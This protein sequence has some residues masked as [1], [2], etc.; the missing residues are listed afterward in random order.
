MSNG[1]GHSLSKI[2]D[3]D[4]CKTGYTYNDLIIMPGIIEFS[5]KDVILDTKISKNFTIK[6]PFVSSPMDTVT[7][8]D[9]AIAMALQGG[10]GFIHC[11]C[12]I[13]KQVEEVKKVKQFTNYSITDPKT[14]KE[15]YTL[16]DFREEYDKYKFSNFPVVDDNNNLVG[17]INIKDTDFIDSPHTK[18]VGDVMTKRD[19][20]I[21]AS[22]ELSLKEAHTILAKTGK[23]FLPII[24][25]I[26]KQESDIVRRKSSDDKVFYDE[27]DESDYLINGKDIPAETPI[28]LQSVICRKDIR[29]MKEYPLCSKDKKGK[30]LVGAAISTHDDYKERATQLIQ[31]G[32]NIILVDSAQ[33]SSSYQTEVI[34]WLKL[35]KLS[36]TKHLTRPYH[37][38]FDII[39]GN[40]VTV[41]QAEYLLEKCQNC[42][43][44]FRVGMGSGSIC[45]TQGVCGVGRAQATAVYHLAKYSNSKGIPII[46]DGGIS[47]SSHII[48]ALLLGASTVMMGS[49]LAGTDE[50]PGDFIYRNGGIRTKKYRGMGSAEALKASKKNTAV[51]GRYLYSSTYNSDKPVAQGVSGY[52]SSKGSINDYVPYIRKCVQL[53]FQ[54]AGIRYLTPI[55]P[56]VNFELRSQSAVNEGNVH[57]IMIV[58]ELN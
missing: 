4:E 18:T 48:K 5:S 53:G 42:I 17:I 33:G 35:L 41:D 52:V 10:I 24:K 51:G 27:P 13:E 2:F 37:N 47:S 30:L 28:R 19:N 8:S 14:V 12:T 23:S 16:L 56:N 7:E 32:V 49:F 9:M 22:N 1:S 57:D 34:N 39:A 21:L 6:T 50:T 44:G 31:A 29:N 20:L 46:A 15:N 25:Y 55:S 38:N 11:N 36:P 26:K 3:S 58:N 40:I 45:T 54:D 43:D